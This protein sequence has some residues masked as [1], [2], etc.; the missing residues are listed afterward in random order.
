MS[1]APRELGHRGSSY[2]IVGDGGSGG[3]DGNGGDAH[4]VNNG[5]IHTTGQAAYGVLAQSIGVIGNSGD[6]GGIVAFTGSG[7][8]GG[9]GG[10]AWSNSARPAPF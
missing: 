1:R 4:A 6:S 10:F 3:Y 7:G 5:S 8:G 9:H 2:G